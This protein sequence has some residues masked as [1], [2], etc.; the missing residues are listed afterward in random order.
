MVGPLVLPT[1]DDTSSLIP[2]LITVDAPRDP[3]K[4]LDP[5]TDRTYLSL[6][7]TNRAVHA[8]LSRIFFDDLPLESARFESCTASDTRFVGGELIASHWDRCNFSKCGFSNI[9]FADACFENCSFFDSDRASGSAF[10][11]C[12]LRTAIFR[13][14][15]LSMSTF[16]VCD[17]FDVKFS[18]C[19][20]RG[21]AFEKPSFAQS[22]RKSGRSKKNTRTT[23]TFESCNLADAILKGTDFSSCSLIDCELVNADLTAALFVNSSLRGTNLTNASLRLANF[24]GAD[25]RGANLTGFDL[26]ELADYAGMQISAGQQ[27]HLLR[28]LGIDVYPDDE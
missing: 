6:R 3:V 2:S 16:F 1:S 12:E 18:G 17:L 10:R 22:L 26:H 15:D 21:V 25:L 4:M 5:E 11:S 8:D 20:M 23:A 14:C 19:R 28:G 27:H 13:N 9:N 24:S 7:Q